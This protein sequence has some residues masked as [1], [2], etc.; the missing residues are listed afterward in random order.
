MN[1]TSLAFHRELRRV[2]LS[3]LIGVAALE[4][5]FTNGSWRF[6]RSRASSASRIKLRA[7]LLRQLQFPRPF[8]SP[9]FTTACDLPANR[10]LGRS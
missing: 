7:S 6:S 3:S 5:I 9:M 10:R 8:A 2:F 4:L 1:Y